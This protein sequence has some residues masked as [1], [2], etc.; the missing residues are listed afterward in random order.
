MAP[1]KLTVTSATLVLTIFSM[2]CSAPRSGPAASP[3]VNSTPQQE[4]PTI[5]KDV[6]LEIHLA[7]RDTHQDANAIALWWE[8]PDFQVSRWVVERAKSANGPWGVIAVLEPG[9]LPSPWRE[10]PGGRSDIYSSIGMEALYPEKN[11]F[12]ASTDVLLRG[13][14]VIPT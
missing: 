7:A 5:W 14:Q 13:E 9:S 1:W 10:G 6:P 12:T 2:S 4:T 8:D 3:Q 11:T